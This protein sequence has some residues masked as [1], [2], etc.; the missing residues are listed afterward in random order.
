MQKRCQHETSAADDRCPVL[1]SDQLANIVPR[2][3]SA[4][5]DLIVHVGV[6]RYVRGKQLAEIAAEL[7]SQFGVELS[8]SSISRS[9]D[10]F[11]A[12]LEALHFDRAPELREAM[13]GGYPLH[14]DA[15]CELGKGGL[16]IGLD[17][18][19]G[20][21]LTAARIATE[22]CAAIS[23]V[24][25]RAVTLFGDPVAAVHDLGNAI[26]QA[27]APLRDRGILDLLC[28]FHLV[29]AIGKAL[30]D[31]L[32]TSLR[33]E[34]HRT[35]LRDELR[36]MLRELSPATSQ[37][38]VRQELHAW[39]TWILEDTRTDHLAYPFDLP[40]RDFLV[41]CR[42]AM[43]HANAWLPHPRTAA[44]TQ[45]I[46]RFHRCSQALAAPSITKIFLSIQ[47]AWNV[48]DD[49]RSVL[50]MTNEDI[51][52][53]TAPPAPPSDSPALAKARLRDI[54][55][56]VSVFKR[57]LRNRQQRESTRR[58][59]GGPLRS[60]S[61]VVLSYLEERYPD[62]LFGHPL[63]YDHLGNPVGVVARTN[64]VL[65]QWFGEHKRRLRRRLGRAKLAR[66][67]ELQPAQA[68]YTANLFHDNYVR[69][70]CGSFSNMPKCFADLDRRHIPIS[71]IK[72]GSTSATMRQNARKL[73]RDLLLCGAVPALR[74]VGRDQH[75]NRI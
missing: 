30:F 1:R 37:K 51:R 58:H 49:F 19:R 67:L 14:I 32:H 36:T 8:T 68:A 21:V 70:V 74:S 7:R 24:I 18:H 75:A 60:P 13:A 4:G 57:Q 43:T 65:E 15:T 53:S 28:H 59:G 38:A 25:E 9:C 45:A 39:L 42:E 35:K 55:A 6:A 61:A 22:N 26:T 10:Q 50:R 71:P 64:N 2:G 23:P 48:F 69:V 27:L 73:D 3:Q 34:L 5:Y 44:E 31:G 63:L 41:R 47:E 40:E 33:Q 29:R 17:G 52:S 20:W 12:Y 46:E 16:L 11:L 54:E 62:G 72:R 66:D 56:K